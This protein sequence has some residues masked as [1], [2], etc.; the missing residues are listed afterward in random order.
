MILAFFDDFDA[1][2][3]PSVPCQKHSSEAQSDAPHNSCRFCV[4][5][6]FCFRQACNDRRMLRMAVYM[7][8]IESNASAFED[9]LMQA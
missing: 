8:G 4:I 3:I 7:D 1:I 6:S 5:L 9:G 2:R